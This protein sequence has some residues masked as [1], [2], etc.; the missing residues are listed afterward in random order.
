MNATDRVP[1]IRRLKIKSGTRNAA[2]N[3]SVSRPAPNRFESTI[4][5]ANPRIL[6]RMVKMAI[7][8]VERNIEDIL[9]SDYRVEP[10]LVDCFS[11]PFLRINKHRVF[12]PSYFQGKL[13]FSRAR[14]FL[15]KLRVPPVYYLKLVFQL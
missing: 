2:K 5:F 6:V 14:L 8:I 1:A 3:I 11:F 10:V 12:Y 13:K 7:K 15:Q 9:L 4:N